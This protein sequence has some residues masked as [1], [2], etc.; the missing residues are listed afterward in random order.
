M[1]EILFWGKAAQN[2][3]NDFVEINNKESLDVQENWP[4]VF[5]GDDDFVGSLQQPAG[6]P[7]F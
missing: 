7:G 1:T 2:N 3:T 6:N 5:N 4:I